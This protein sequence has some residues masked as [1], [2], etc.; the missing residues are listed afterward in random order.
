MLNNCE[1]TVCFKA[2]IFNYSNTQEVI[3]TI[4]HNNITF[5]QHETVCFPVRSYSSAV[6]QIWVFP[7]PCP[8]GS[9]C[10]GE[11]R[12]GG[13]SQC[14]TEF[15][16]KECQLA[17][18]SQTASVLPKWFAKWTVNVPQPPMTSHYHLVQWSHWGN[19]YCAF[20]RSY[21]TLSLSLA[22]F[23]FFEDKKC[24]FP[25]LQNVLYLWGSY[26]TDSCMI[27]YWN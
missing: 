7:L 1:H 3:I 11:A 22:F 19:R 9:E 14:H 15:Q 5:F 16:L 26:T 6:Y 8:A 12:V 25:M 27:K 18:C 17:L 20:G 21:T 23:F 4:Q 2:E 10:G 24:S 13:R